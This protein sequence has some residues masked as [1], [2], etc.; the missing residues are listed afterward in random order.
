[1]SDCPFQHTEIRYARRPF[2]GPGGGSEGMEENAFD[3]VY[4]AVGITAT[5]VLPIVIGFIAV[6][7]ERE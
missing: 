4:L 7:R 5:L 1:M 6:F 2:H 3:L